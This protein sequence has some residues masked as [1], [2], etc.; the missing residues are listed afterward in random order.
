MWEASPS[1]IVSRES[2]CSICS[3][4]SSEFSKMQFEMIVVQRESKFLKNIE[5]TR[6][7]SQFNVH[8]DIF[9]R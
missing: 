4:V 8:M 3:G 1:N 2:W 5:V 9:G 7:R 6:L